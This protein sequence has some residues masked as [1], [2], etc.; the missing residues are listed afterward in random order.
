MKRTVSN[1]SMVDGISEVV[2][3]YDSRILQQEL[4]H[5]WQHN[6]SSTITLEDINEEIAAARAERSQ[7]SN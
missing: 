4:N 6:E 2:C 5:M 3:S 7:K 1:L